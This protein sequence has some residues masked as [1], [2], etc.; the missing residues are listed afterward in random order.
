MREVQGEG[1][2]DKRNE[3]GRVRCD[4]W[5][6]SLRRKAQWGGSNI[7]FSARGGRRKSL[8]GICERA[9]RFLTRQDQLALAN[10]MESITKTAHQAI[11]R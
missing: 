5:H 1:E 3:R 8:F 2:G 6:F 10:V 11:I 9:R 7:G 4:C